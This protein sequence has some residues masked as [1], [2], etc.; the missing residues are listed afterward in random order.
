MPR[1]KI[2]LKGLDK[3]VADLNK[4]GKSVEMPVKVGITK[5]TNYCKKVAKEKC[6][7][8][9]GTLKGSIHSEVRKKAEKIEGEVST[10]LEYAAYVELGTGQRG[11]ETNTNPELEVNYRADWKG[12]QAKPYMYPAYLETREK[13]PKFLEDEMNKVL[14]GLKN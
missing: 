7:V 3:I 13:L 14:R 1:M 10:I 9:T 2:E 6:P 8:D 12:Q 5:A 4:F 11:K